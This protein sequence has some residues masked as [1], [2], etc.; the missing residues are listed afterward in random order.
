MDSV[1]TVEPE[2]LAAQLASGSRQA[3]ATSLNLLDDTRPQQRAW[4]AELLNEIR[5]VEGSG[6]SHL[7][8]ITGPPG[9]GKSSLTAALISEWRRRDKRVGVLAV[10]PSS[11][12]SGGAL[13]GD[14]LRMKTS[15][16]DDGVFVRSL[17][18]RGDF[19]GLSPQVWPMSLAMLAAFDTVVVETVG[20]GQ[21]EI[22]VAQTC[23]TTC[24]VAQPGAGDSI[25]FLKAGILEIPDLL[26]VNK[27]D[28]GDVAQRTLNELRTA[29]GHSRRGED[30]I[31]P[32]LGTSATTNAGV[33]ELADALAAHR[34]SIGHSL[35]QLRAG[36]QAQ[37]VAKRIVHAYGQSGLEKLG[38]AN[39]L[40]Q[41][42]ASGTDNPFTLYDTL[43]ATLADNNSS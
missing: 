38:G 2:Q 22:D 19:G 36:N 17:S 23:D 31:V 13:L 16:E 32:V 8:G 40:Q 39:A 4:A 35:P 18:S 24:F 5:K 20:V 28:M 34:S 15:A 3:L 10:D 41:R 26:V 25:Q 42:L 27:V 11:P 37:W 21:R 9:V 43:A 30:W 33:A 7:V 12:V 6:N 14:R 1:A 29:L